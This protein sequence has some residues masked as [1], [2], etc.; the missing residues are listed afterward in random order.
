M[1]LV[2][3][4]SVARKVSYF[5]IIIKWYRNPFNKARL[6]VTFE[7]KIRTRISSVG[8][9][10]FTCDLICDVINCY[11]FSFDIGKISV[12][13]MIKSQFFTSFHLTD[14]PEVEF[15]GG[16]ASDIINLM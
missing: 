15:I 13:Y 9:K 10:Y 14:C 4:Y 6:F 12:A 2:Y 7:C 3:A 16:G 11:A 1:H 5:R 8:I